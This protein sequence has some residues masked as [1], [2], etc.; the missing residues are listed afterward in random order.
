MHLCAPRVR[1]ST[2]RASPP[3]RRQNFSWDEPVLE[4]TLLEVVGEAFAL[5]ATPA[6]LSYEEAARV[7]SQWLGVEGLDDAARAALM[8]GT[9]AKLFGF[10]AC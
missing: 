7:P 8:G 10:E 6:A 5:E 1:L 2:P 3:G 9:A 4:R